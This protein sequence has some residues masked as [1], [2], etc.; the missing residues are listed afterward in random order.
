MT[1]EPLDRILL[2]YLFQLSN[3]NEGSLIKRN[4]GFMHPVIPLSQL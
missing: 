2:K 4:F 3:I 1:I